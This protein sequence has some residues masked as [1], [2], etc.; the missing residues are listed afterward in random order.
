M[1]AMI[2]ALVLVMMDYPAAADGI[3]VGRWCDQ[4]L[5][6][7]PEADNIMELFALDDGK[8]EL[9]TEFGDGSKGTE[10]LKIK[11]GDGEQTYVA[12]NS[13]SGEHYRIDPSTG[14]LQMFDKDGLF[15]IS[16]KLENRPKPGECGRVTLPVTACAKGKT[17]FYSNQETKPVD[18][19]STISKSECVTI[20]KIR[21]SAG[22]A[23]REG[24]AVGWI[25]M[26]AFELE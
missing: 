23:V 24:G 18:A 13:S 25:R 9:K 14:N 22:R 11:A 17:P 7:L 16:K 4:P 12:V 2:L 1:K 10:E 20:N 8:A 15:R 26:G 21:N 19:I 3:L 5:S 6:T